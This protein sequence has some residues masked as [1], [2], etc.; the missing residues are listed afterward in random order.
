MNDIAYSNF[1]TRQFTDG[2]KLAA[3]SDI[4]RL[5]PEP[6]PLPQRYIA[7]FR[8]KG[9]VTTRD[10]GVCEGNLFIVGIFLPNDYLRRAEVPEVLT[11][12]GPT[13]VFHPNIAGHRGLICVG[14]LG[15]GSDLVS[16]LYQIFEIIV[17]RK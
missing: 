15:P 8:C 2:T 13:S 4:L 5:L 11:W 1:L 14:R 16:L 9:L 7:E 12:L 6:G 3:D 17:Y 10:G